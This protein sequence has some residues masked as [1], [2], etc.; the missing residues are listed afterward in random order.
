MKKR[1]F[2]VFL[3]SVL[4]VGTLPIEPLF[5]AGIDRETLQDANRSV[6]SVPIPRN[7][8]A[9][10]FTYELDDDGNATI[11]GYSGSETNV[12]IPE[13][14]DGYPVVK[15][16]AK[17][18]EKK[19]TIQSVKIADS[20]LSIEKNAF[21][22]C[23]GLTGVKLSNNLVNL[24]GGAFA[25][26]YNLTE[27]WI[28]KTLKTTGS[29]PFKGS[30]LTSVEIESGAEIVASNLFQGAAGL[31]SVVIPTTV[32]TI[33]ASAFSDCGNFKL[34]GI[35]ENVTTIGASA[36]SG[37]ASLELPCIP[38]S[39]TKIGDRAFKDCTKLKVD[40]PEAL[41]EI[42]SYVF[43]GCPEVTEVNIP[44]TL[45][46]AGKD[47]PF[48]K[49][50]I[51]KAT[52]LSGNKTLLPAY[53]FREAA[54]LTEVTIPETVTEIGEYAF[55]NCKNLKFKN[56]L[57]LPSRLE[58]LGRYAFGYCTSVTGVWIPK[59]LK[60]TGSRG[61][62]ENSGLTAAEIED[63]IEIL[64]ANLLKNAKKLTDVNIPQSVKTIS[65]SVFEGCE[66]L[67][68]L[69]I[70]DSVMSY[71]NYTFSGTAL[72]EF[73]LTD[74]IQKIGKCLFKNCFALQ[75]FQWNNVITTVPQETFLGC[76][77]LKE[78]K[79]PNVVTVIDSQAFEKCAALPSIT[80]PKCLTTIG[81]S[82]FLDCASLEGITIPDGVRTLGKLAFKNCKALADL[83]ISNC[84]QEIPEQC[85]FECPSLKKVELPYSI[86]TIG[87]L[88]FANCTG[89][90]KVT[91]LQNVSVIAKNA[92][93]YADNMT[94]YGYEGSSAQDFAANA[95]V[96]FVPID[97]PATNVRL[98]QKSVELWKKK[99]IQL[100]PS[101]TPRIFT[102]VVKWSSSNEK[103]AT[104]DDCGMVTAVNLGEATITIKAGTKSAT[105]KVTVLQPVT[106]INLNKTAITIEKGE[107]FQLVPTIKPSNASNKAVTWTSGDK[108]VATVDN[109]GLV[110]GVGAGTVTITAT[111]A[112]GS[113]VSKQCEVTVHVHSFNYEITRKPST[114]AT[115]IL[116]GT[117]S[118]C[119]KITTVT[120]PKLS[121]KDYNYTVVKEPTCTLKGLG[122]YTWKNTDC[123]SVI[124]EANLDALG[125]DLVVDSVILT[126]DEAES[127]RTGTCTRCGEKITEKVT[128]H[129]FVDVNKE[130]FYV[131]VL[132]A[133]Y[134]NPQVTAGTSATKFSPYDPCTRGQVVTFLWRAYGKVQPTSTDNPFVDT[135]STAYYYDAMRWAVENNIT[136]GT[137]STHF[138]PNKTCTRAEVVTFLWR[139]AGS[140]NPKSTKNPFVDVKDGYYYKAVLWAVEKGITKGTN[141]T[142]FEPNAPCTRGQVV[143]FLYRQ[144]GN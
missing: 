81:A 129:P 116:T 136:K 106:A 42:G 25:N 15:I 77:Q 52:I 3:A 83:T 91:I 127:T 140:P 80:L 37:C 128:N 57:S 45:E 26:C 63:G 112:D 27:I 62:F 21:N 89:L 108:T 104:V 56:R 123:G 12:V 34:N 58:T 73:I 20:V 49:S 107:D 33:G 61:P 30:G 92:F 101:F 78:V 109:N 142:H 135:V 94:I 43:E 72:Q 7:G 105:C 60:T 117:C 54:S 36:F 28:P 134:H 68:S 1:I 29:G 88:A 121:Q 75:K 103:V 18:F 2:S 74:Q 48:N 86:K 13:E 53:L 66:S 70:P 132:W 124:I 38:Y 59:T 65:D 50:S 35:P 137:N 46:S 119:G 114:S 97:I 96:A 9:M 125:H 69:S 139:A 99:T 47:G 84:I 39:V 64:P 51:Q 133:Y 122:R 85:F 6:V 76:V 19:T 71:G 95:D 144:Q 111:A 143:T 93:S 90:E 87:T 120:L 11:M 22:G 31:K 55:Y 44:N 16:G 32:I 102:D 115:G 98:N 82:A 5:A 100:I 110:V 131:P 10:D 113:G 8:S 79:I 130:F 67:N 23:T 24:G 141:A 118:V 17:A 4:V 14:I 126:P 40:L 41:R 138:E